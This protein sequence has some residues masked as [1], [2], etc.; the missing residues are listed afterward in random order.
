MTKR[1]PGQPKSPRNFY[2]TPAKALVPCFARLVRLDGKTFSEPCVGEGHLAR[3]LEKIDLKCV[4]VSDLAYGT[5]AF[6]LRRSDLNGADMVITNPPWDAEIM[7]PMI[8]HFVWMEL[9]V[10]MLLDADWAHTLRAEAY[11]AYCT[12]IVSVGR[13]KWYPDSKHQSLDNAAW[14]R[15]RWSEKVEGTRFWTR[16]GV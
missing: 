5:D 7:P 12:D 6:S 16:N 15:F 9:P 11:M 8:W 2:P 13:L 14:Y 4:H 10:W 1:N 3:H